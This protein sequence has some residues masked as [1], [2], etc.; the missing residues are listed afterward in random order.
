MLSIIQHTDY[1]AYMREAE[2]KTKELAT[3]N[4]IDCDVAFTM[5]YKSVKNFDAPFPKSR[6]LFILTRTIDNSVIRKRFIKDL[7]LKLLEEYGDAM[8]G[9]LLLHK[10]GY[11]RFPYD[12]FKKVCEDMHVKSIDSFKTTQKSRYYDAYMKGS[13]NYSIKHFYTT[14]RIDIVEHNKKIRFYESQF[15]NQLID[16]LNDTLKRHLILIVGPPNIGKTTFAERLHG[17]KMR[18]IRTVVCNR[19]VRENVSIYLDEKDGNDDENLIMDGEHA[20]EEE[21]NMFI[22]ACKVQ[23]MPCVC[24]LFDATKE[25]CIYM[26]DSLYNESKGAIKKRPLHGITLFYNRYRVP[27][28]SEG[29][30]KIIKIPGIPDN[31]MF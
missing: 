16:E 10:D 3:V 1:I 18:Y 4:M 20:N 12:G 27:R 29:I 5:N 7:T 15:I 11:Y 26:C 8:Y 22:K 19:K 23:N 6:L 24:V 9:C 28:V 2:A 21:R 14:K 31:K 30:K 13:F 17:K 25:E